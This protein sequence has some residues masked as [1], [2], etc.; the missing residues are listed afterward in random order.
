MMI[1]LKF[2]KPTW[3]ILSVILFLIS[4]CA[5]PQ[6]ASSTTVSTDPDRAGDFVLVTADPQVTATPFQPVAPTDILVLNPSITAAVEGLTPTATASATIQ[7]QASQTPVNTSIPPAATVSATALPQQPTKIADTEVPP[8]PALQA[9]RTQ[10]TLTA[11]M[12][13]ANH[14][15][16]V[17]EVVIY[18]NLSQGVLTNIS[19][20]VNPNLWK[21]VFY[22]QT[23]A[24]NDVAVTNFSLSG[25]WLVVNL[26][27]P[28]QPGQVIKL[29]LDYNLIL[30]YSSAKFENFGY[31]ARQT[32]LIDWYPFIPPYRNGQWILPDPYAYGENL[33]YDKADFR[34]SLEFT[35]PANAPVVAAS[36]EA[37]LVQGVLVYELP[38][39]RNF[40][41][42]A[43]PEYLIGVADASGVKIYNY[44]FAGEYLAAG[45]VLELTQKA[46]NTYIAEFGPY[47]HTILSVCETDLNDGLETDGMYFLAKNFYSTY[48]G[49]VKNNLSMIAVHETA[50]QW[51][52]GAVASNQAVEPWLDEAL[53]TYS[54]NVFYDKNYPEVL[55]WWWNY[56]VNAFGASGWVD[57]Q[58]Y[59]TTSFRAY[60]NAVYF[61]GA[62]FMQTLR[63]RIGDEAFFAFIKD[64]YA[65]NN[66][67][68]VTASDF[69]EVLALHTDKDV[70]DIIKLYF[71]YQ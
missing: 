49:S 6:T 10:Y 65:R 55:N 60:V 54:E 53:S 22:L 19:F 41:I 63:D 45:R 27:V 14:T 36:A 61:N 52:Y 70:S 12:D 64:Y 31:T 13:Y 69:F 16:S 39:A 8:K 51:W 48:D 23:L 21:G 29:T 34:V 40:T 42:S 18:P 35:D 24:V 30:P 9:D 67:R 2:D 5:S 28:M 46:V 38:N 32:N 11:V 62:H 17:H 71:R 59:D 68:V 47:P 56:R 66:G 20:G 57:S 7:P 25:Q 1:T 43:S 44:Y 15:V 58:V 37:N 26:D 3:P 4:S 50:H 33:V